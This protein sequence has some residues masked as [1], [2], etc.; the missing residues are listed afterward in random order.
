[1][2]IQHNIHNRA[3]SFQE[4][5]IRILVNVGRIP[6]ED[7]GPEC[8][9]LHKTRYHGNL[10]HQLPTTACFITFHKILFALKTWSKDMVTVA[11]LFSRRKQLE[12]KYHVQDIEVF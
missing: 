6:T 4:H 9:L 12:T 3:D 2:N 7:Q 8:P 5:D 10:L 1:M 11:R